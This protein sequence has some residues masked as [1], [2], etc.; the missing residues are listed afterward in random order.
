[1]G[2]AIAEP[3]GAVAT[4]DGAIGSFEDLYRQT[5]RRVYAYVAS[6]LRVAVTLPRELGG[7][8]RRGLSTGRALADARQRS[9]EPRT[10]SATAPHARPPS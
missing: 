6:L 8:R 3:L 4:G 1:M 5:S 9:A 10:R 2:D 7:G